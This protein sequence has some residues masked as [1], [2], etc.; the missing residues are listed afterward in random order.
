MIGRLLQNFIRNRSRSRPLRLRHGYLLLNFK[1]PLIFL[2]HML[3]PRL[4]GYVRLYVLLVANHF[5]LGIDSL[6]AVHSSVCV[7]ACDHFL[8]LVVKTLTS[9]VGKS[10]LRSRILRFDLIHL[11]DHI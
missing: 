11:V 1:K 5:L 10:Y 7:E 8:V 9:A 2:S 4:H 6:R 3:E